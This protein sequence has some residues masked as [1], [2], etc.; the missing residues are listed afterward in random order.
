MLLHRPQDGLDDFDY[1]GSCLLPGRQAVEEPDGRKH[2]QVV[3]IFY[4]AIQ[5]GQLRLLQVRSTLNLA[6]CVKYA[7]V[8][9]FLHALLVNDIFLVL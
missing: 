6:S 5:I 1:Y 9:R 7:R 8:V 3:F 2:D 4:D